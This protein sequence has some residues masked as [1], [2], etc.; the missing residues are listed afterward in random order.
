MLVTNLCMVSVW[1][2]IPKRHT[3]ANQGFIRDFSL[4]GGGGGGEY[5]PIL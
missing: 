2:H 1:C 5:E 3:I 4:W